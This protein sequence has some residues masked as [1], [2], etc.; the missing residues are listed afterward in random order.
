MIEAKNQ[1]WIEQQHQ[2]DEADCVHYLQLDLLIQ[3]DKEVIIE[4]GKRNHLEGENRFRLWIVANEVRE[5]LATQY[6][7]LETLVKC[8]TKECYSVMEAIPEGMTIAPHANTATWMI[9]LNSS[10]Y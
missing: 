9:L 3:A 6:L 2:H 5:A 1:C 10:G 4:E 8:I 7:P